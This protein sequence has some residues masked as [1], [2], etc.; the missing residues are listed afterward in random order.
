MQVKGGRA[1]DRAVRVGAPLANS[2]A[3]GTRAAE[4]AAMAGPRMLH[5]KGN[6]RDIDCIS[7]YFQQS[8]AHST[9]VDHENRLSTYTFVMRER[10]R[11]G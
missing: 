2:N 7:G 3:G 1:H 10:K 11:E 5:R 9:T 6:A 4:P 8:R